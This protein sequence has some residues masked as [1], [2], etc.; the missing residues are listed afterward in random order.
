MFDDRTL[1]LGSILILFWLQVGLTW[2]LTLIETLLLVSLPLLIG[3]SIDGLLNQDWQPFYLLGVTMVLLIVIS[4]GRR[5]F[6]TRAYGKMRVELGVAVVDKA[7]GA[8]VSK[9]NARLDMSREL[10]TFL[11][12]EAPIVIMALLQVVVSLVI[13]FSFHGVLAA[14]AGAATILAL[15][16]YAAA[17]GRFFKLNGDLNSQAEEQVSVLESG[18]RES[19]LQHL[20]NLRRH[21]VR[22]SDTEAIVYGLIF[23]VLLSMLGINLW[24]AATQ[25]DASPGQIFSIVTYS[26]EFIESAVMLPAAL[27]SLTRISEITQRLN[28]LAQP[29]ED[30][31]SAS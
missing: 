8:P 9:I 5:L 25:I 23:V 28:A 31:A 13:L 22:I 19:I 29:V 30:P 16:I 6:D 7:Q 21:A 2:A 10:I 11:E 24:F 12:T 3:F 20:S 15:V 26:Y 1:S 27:Q 14:T 17:S 4:V 18:I